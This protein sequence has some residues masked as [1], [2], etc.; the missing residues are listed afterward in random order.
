MSRVINIK[1]HQPLKLR[2]ILGKDVDGL[3]EAVGNLFKRRNGKLIA[4]NYVGII[5]TTSNLIVEILPKIDLGGDSEP[6][7]EKT[8]ELFLGML[9]CWRRIA[10]TLP[11]SDIRAMR[12]FPMLEIFVHQF[13]VHLNA[14]ARN[15]LAKR[16]IP[17]EENLPYLRGRLLF[18]E[19]IRENL[20]N[21]TRFYVAHNEL[22]VDRPA[23]R[24]IQSVLTRLTHEVQLNENRQLLRQ[25]TAVFENVPQSTNLHVDWQKHHVDRSMRHYQPVMQWAGLFLFNQGL[26][27]YS[28]RYSNLSLLFPMEQV[29]EDFVTDSFRRYQK[30]YFVTAQH[31]Q[32]KLT[33]I[34]G[35]PTFTMKPDI[36]LTDREHKFILDAKWKEISTKNDDHKHGIDQADMY[37]LYAYGKCYR[38]DV[39]ALIYPKT[40]FFRTE[41]HYKFFD[42]LTLICLPFDVS[43][44][45]SSVVQSIQTLQDCLPTE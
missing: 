13:L 7:D 10:K 25:L 29:F 35:V 41:L 18:R 6:D 14:L 9:R 38:C 27:T 31:P 39:V 15:G 8:K 19:N 23:N 22:S 24:L 4:S 20:V 34:N 5:T 11:E 17:M 43:K 44:P 12:K 36:F 1:E 28:G 30:K 45:E 32:E 2:D 37:Q 40:R 33:T 21:L 42:G 26:T 16:Y 3:E